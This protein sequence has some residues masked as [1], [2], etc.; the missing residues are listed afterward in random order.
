[1]TAEFGLLA[2]AL[3]GATVAPR[4]LAR[5][6]WVERSPWVGIALWQGLSASVFLAT[7]LGGLAL[8]LPAVPLSDDLAVLLSACGAALRAQYETPGGASASAM[9]AALALGALGRITYCL[10]LGTRQARAQRRRQLHSLAVLARR[11][12]H[13]GAVVVDHDVPTAYCLPGRGRHIVITSAVLDTLGTDEV[14]AVLAHERAHLLARHHLLL[15][16][17]ESFRRAFSWVPL[18][19]RAHSEVS[20]LVEM[21]ADDIAARSSERLTLVT[22]L[23]RL[24]EASNP[25]G[26]LGAGGPTSLARVRRL[27][28]P[29]RPLGATRAAGAL[30]AAALLALAPMAIVAAPAAT[31]V[32][33]QLC[34]V[35]F[36]TA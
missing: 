7:V 33:S 34:P 20:R 21:H 29:Q 1:V 9:G 15:A 13:I 27:M 22:A 30:I 28:A 32:T 31:A 5:A 25:A 16:V 8:A 18:F 24:A 19:R 3:L 36:P 10:A 26:A 11:D 17:T 2:F 23:V 14:A 35:E 4:L 6:A 12:D